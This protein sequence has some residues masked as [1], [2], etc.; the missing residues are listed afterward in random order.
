MLRYR[1]GDWRVISTVNE[2]PSRV[3]FFSLAH[4]HEAYE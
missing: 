3:A 1:I 2:E 4:R